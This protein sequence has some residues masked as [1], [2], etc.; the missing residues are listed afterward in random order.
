[1]DHKFKI[2][3]GADHA[4][5]RLKTAIKKH[6][7]ERGWSYKDLGDNKLVADDDY[8]DYAKKVANAVS[9]GKNNFGILVC[10]SGH[11]MAIAANR[12]KKI[13]AILGFSAEA[14]IVA[15]HDSD[16]NI[17]C[18]AGRFLSTDHALNIV[19]RFLDTPFSEEERHTRR[20]KKLS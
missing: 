19:D 3:L 4:G 8:P 14:A 2:Y 18:L 11:G 7:D 1:M 17:L 6:L 9:K 15:R 12:H 10:G 5:F 16:S 20:I 13:R